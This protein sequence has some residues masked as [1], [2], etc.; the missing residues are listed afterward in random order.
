M[1]EEEK[2]PHPGPLPHT[3]E[4]EDFDYSLF[5]PPERTEPAR[6]YLISPQ[7]VGGAFRTGSRPRSVTA[8]P[9]RSSCG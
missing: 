3:G 2:N 6:L 5:K 1:S 4:G 8:A 7:D 9:P